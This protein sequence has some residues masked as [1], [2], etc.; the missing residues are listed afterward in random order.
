M[1]LKCQNDEVRNKERGGKG[2]QGRLQSLKD[3]CVSVSEVHQKVNYLKGR[4]GKFF[5]PCTCIT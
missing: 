5:P 1:S 3:V 4:F 2:V